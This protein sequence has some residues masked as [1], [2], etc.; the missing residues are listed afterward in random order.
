MLQTRSS[1]I[2]PIALEFT[3]NEAVLYLILKQ[4]QCRWRDTSTLLIEYQED[5]CYMV[6]RFRFAPY[7]S[8]K[9]TMK[10][11]LSQLE[12]KG[13]VIH[14]FY[15]EYPG[16]E[17]QPNF[18][19]LSILREQVL[20]ANEIFYCKLPK[21]DKFDILLHSLREDI[22]KCSILYHGNLGKQNY[23][24]FSYLHFRINPL[25]PLKEFQKVKAGQVTQGVHFGETYSES[26]D[27]DEIIV[28]GPPPTD[29]D[30]SEPFGCSIM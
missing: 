7:F 16:L 27:N 29:H 20:G 17:V 5:S 25:F 4:E 22:S 13:K 8:E 14:H 11:K 6:D 10:S 21:N 9:M 12:L 30:P 15:M 24:A 3:P 28:E 1:N 19:R 2:S 26:Q 23:S 18:V